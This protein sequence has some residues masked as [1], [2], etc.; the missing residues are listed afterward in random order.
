MGFFDRDLPSGTGDDEPADQVLHAAHPD[1]PRIGPPTEYFAPGIL[2]WT[3]E[4]GAGPTAR[5]RLLRVEVWPNG[6]GLELGTY[7]RVGRPT[8]IPAPFP[9]GAGDREGLHVG[10]LFADG[11]RAS[12]LVGRP[13]PTEPAIEPTLRL[14]GGGGST[15]HHLHRA[16]L[17]TLPPEGPFTV[18]VDWPAEQVPET[19]TVLDGTAVRAALADTIELWPDLPPGPP[20]HGVAHMAQVTV[21]GT[22]GTV[23]G[24]TRPPTPRQP[25]P[26]PDT[27]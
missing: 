15:F 24:T 9:F 11:T 20:W 2:P 7:R 3:R 12:S 17:S 19:H 10:V 25:G 18:I 14:L 13:S 21:S 27:P 22:G 23:T 16:Y 1:E 5:V 26:H 4:L 8:R 6:I